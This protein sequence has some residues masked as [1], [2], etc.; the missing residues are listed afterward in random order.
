MEVPGR[1]G[2]VDRIILSACVTVV[3][4]FQAYYGI[5]TYHAELHRPYSNA[6]EVASFIAAKGW[7]RNVIAALTDI[8][9][10]AVIAYLGAERFYFLNGRRFGS[11]TIWDQR[12]LTSEVEA[13]LSDLDR[14]KR[15]VVLIVSLRSDDP[16]LFA[17]H[18]YR[19]VA[20]FTGASQR[21]EDFVLYR[22]ASRR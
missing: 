22:R 13:A 19:E 12:R 15:P 8:K 1:S 16:A 4:A 20:R 3:L 10:S 11:F 9:V 18:G 5:N 7:T 21:D 2:P 14:K 6:R 17:R